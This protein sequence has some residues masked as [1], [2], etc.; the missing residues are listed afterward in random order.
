[1]REVV[2]E[3]RKKKELKFEDTRKGTGEEYLYGIRLLAMGGWLA[4]FGSVFL[5][6]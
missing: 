2:G 5:F 3:L 4:C 6:D 1:M